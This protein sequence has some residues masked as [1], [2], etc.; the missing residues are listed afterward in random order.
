MFDRAVDVQVRR[1]RK[2]LSDGGAGDL[3][4]TVRSEGYMFSVKPVGQ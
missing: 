3:M 1:L 4:V 2:K